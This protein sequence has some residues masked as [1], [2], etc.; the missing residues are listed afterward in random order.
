MIRNLLTYFM[1]RSLVFLAPIIL[2]PVLTHKI[3]S[4][5]YGVIALFSSVQ[6]MVYVFIGMG[7][8]GAVVRAY[9]DRTD[10]GFNFNEY[11]FNAMFINIFL[12]LLS[13]APFFYL[14]LTGLI[15]LPLAVSLILPI[16]FVA[17]SLKEYKL[18][19]WNIQGAAK[20]FVL[21]E[22]GYVILSLVLSIV[23]VIYIFQD[24]RSRVYAIIFAEFLFLIFSMLFLFKEDKPVFKFNKAY[25]VDVL[26]FGLPLLPHSFAV[27]LLFSSD[28]L[29]LGAL[30]GLTEVGIFSVAASISTIM[31]VLV[32]AADQTL[33]PT[34]YSFFKNQTQKGKKYYVAGFYMYLALASMSGIVLYLI[35]PWGISA[36]I[37]PEFEKSAKYVG[38]LIFGQIGYTM[39]RY[40]VKAI[41]F[42]KKTH[43]VSIVT[44][45]SALIGAAMQYILIGYYGILGAAVGTAS[46]FIL[47]FLLALY[48]SNKLY[49]MPWNDSI[50][51]IKDIPGIL[52]SYIRG[53]KAQ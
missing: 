31:M 46:M 27:G 8:A 9:I 40:V 22:S 28:K 7:G 11:L 5:D 24:W 17:S 29:L 43:L 42:S 26:K 1:G 14:Y 44:L 21:F 3:S 53:T 47:S 13:L 39:Y 20:R 2:L 51:I 15:D 36:F 10:M 41:F 16:I 30:M 48:F 45:V 6:Q 52:Y 50:Q 37:G 32:I 33:Q 18:K 34:L 12:F 35:T 49:A 4:E 23:L 25:C 38:I 19:L